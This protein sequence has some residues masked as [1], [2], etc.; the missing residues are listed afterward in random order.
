MSADLLGRLTPTVLRDDARRVVHQDHVVP[1]ARPAHMLRDGPA[2]HRQRLH[3]VL[4]RAL[5][6]VQFNV[7]TYSILYS[8]A[9]R[10]AYSAHPVHTA[11]IIP[12]VIMPTKRSRRRF[13]TT[14]RTGL[15]CTPVYYMYYI[16]LRILL[17]IWTKTL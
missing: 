13:H 10:H 17:N 8:T 15:V 12:V 6:H 16:R 9:L 14:C 2:V 11:A 5:E 1:H 7:S 3:Q 4:H